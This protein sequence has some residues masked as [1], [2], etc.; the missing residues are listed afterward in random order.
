MT[1]PKAKMNIPMTLACVLMCLTMF[2]FYFT[3]GLY[4]R[5]ITRAEASDSARVI[6]FGDL[7]L[8]ESGD[9]GTDATPVVVIPGVDLSKKVNIAFTPAESATY[10]FVELTPGTDWNA[11]DYV[12][13]TAAGGKLSWSVDS[14][15]WTHLGT[16]ANP[17]VY[18]CSLAANEN[19]SKDFI[20][21]NGAITVSDELTAAELN[22]LSNIN[23]SVRATVVQSGGFADVTEAW[24]SVK[25]K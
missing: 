19:F 20:A 14:A 13:F 12:N 3:G 18:Y 25:N 9:F 16:T 4:A 5:Y 24:N 8:T 22:A 7:T 10:V 21:N 6:K 2:S 11:A 17:Y 15:K 23:I 1:R